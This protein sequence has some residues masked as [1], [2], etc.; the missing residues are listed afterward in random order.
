VKYG[1]RLAAGTR[2]TT[3]EGV[4]VGLVAPEK[5]IDW[6]GDVQGPLFERAQ[7]IAQAY[8]LHVLPS[9]EF[10]D[11]TTLVRTQAETLID[12]LTFIENV[13]NDGVL[14]SELTI[15]RD[16][17]LRSARSPTDLQLVLAGP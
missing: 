4:S 15:L 12:E 6:V 2:F 5:E 1:D 13:V 16:A 17:A 3:G 8:D 11:T 7:L 10:Y 14:D 9:I